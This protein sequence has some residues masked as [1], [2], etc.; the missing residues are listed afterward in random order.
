MNNNLHYAVDDIT[1]NFKNHHLDLANKS[2]AFIFMVLEIN[3]KYL[4][5]DK[6]ELQNKHTVCN[7]IAQCIVSDQDHAIVNFILCMHEQEADEQDLVMGKCNYEDNCSQLQI[8]NDI[9]QLVTL[10]KQLV[11]MYQNQSDSENNLYE[12]FADCYEDSMDGLKKFCMLYPKT[13]SQNN[14][15]NLDELQNY[16]QSLV[17]DLPSD[18]TFVLELEISN[19]IN[20]DLDNIENDQ[21]VRFVSHDSIAIYPKNVLHYSDDAIIVSVNG[22]SLHELYKNSG[23]NLLEA[24]LRYYVKNP[25]IDN[26][27]AKT[28]A[29]NPHEFWYLNNGLT[30]ICNHFKVYDN[31]VELFGFSIVNGGQT[32]YLI[33]KMDPKLENDLYIVCKIVKITDQHEQ[34]PHDF[35]LKIAQA[36]N[37]QKPIND[38]DLKTNQPE[39]LDFAKLCQ[40]YGLIYEVRRGVARGKEIWQRG[41]VTSC[42]KLLLA[43]ILQLPA[44]ARTKR[45][46]IFN[47]VNYDILFPDNPIKLNHH[48][49]ITSQLSKIEYCFKRYLT[50]G[51]KKQPRWA[52]QIK[53]AKNAKTEAIAFVSLLSRLANGSLSWAK[54]KTD[55]LDLQNFMNNKTVNAM[56]SDES[57]EWFAD[58]INFK[59]I[60][61]PIITD[62]DDLQDRLTVIFDY[63]IMNGY[64]NYAKALAN[65]PDLTETNYL[66]TNVAYYQFLIAIIDHLNTDLPQLFHDLM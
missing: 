10:Y 9:K 43:C 37:Q 26:E 42:G 57:K 49:L 36:S 7:E 8:K 13:L 15:I 14:A 12:Q 11:S 44:D 39:Q 38:Q 62:I 29:N 27:I 2:N 55:L 20:S 24:N 17:K 46:A 34:N 58:S 35:I 1:E 28:I 32:T 50:R 53:Y 18:Q 40:K 54:L 63:V 47:P 31:K 59:Q 64:K 52:K 19:A 33:N 48:A 61:N 6:Q 45:S 16:F 3:D 21:P 23:N 56:I 66:K 41:N 51:I 22:K 4:H 5:F 65:K 60:Y 30:I 25:K